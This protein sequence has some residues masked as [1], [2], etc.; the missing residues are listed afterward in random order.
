MGTVAQYLALKKTT[1]IAGTSGIFVMWNLLPCKH[2]GGRGSFLLLV[3]VALPLRSVVLALVAADHPVAII[4]IFL[5]AGT[6]T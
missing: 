2:S 6:D 5:S 4:L 1:N 3:L